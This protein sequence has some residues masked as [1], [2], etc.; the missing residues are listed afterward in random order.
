MTRRD[1]EQGNIL[2]TVLLIV[3]VLSVIAVAVMDDIR[4]AVRRA[5]N[6]QER[7]QADFYAI[8][9]E[10][11]AMQLIGQAVQRDPSRTLLE[12]WA[13]EPVIFPLDDGLIEAR[14]DDASNCFNLNALVTGGDGAEREADETHVALLRNL[15]VALDVGEGDAEGLANAAAD[16]IDSDSVP[17]PQGAEDYYYQGLAP[18]YRAA[19]TLMAEVS[20]VRAV[21]GFTQEIYARVAPFLCAHPTTEFSEI[22]VN[23]LNEDDAPLLMM[24][25]GP[26]N[27][28]AADA[29]SAIAA[30]GPNGYRSTDDFW[31]EPAFA[32][33]LPT[34]P[35]EL[36][37]TLKTRY[38]DL[39]VRVAY[40]QAFVQQQS[41]LEVRPAR[42]V[43][44]ISRRYGVAP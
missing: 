26:Q 2:I 31:A 4:F 42:D 9:A 29:R 30:R 21:R 27:L 10:Q 41:V 13:R 23:T 8:G 35:E 5:A 39:K 33:K 7:A 14:I 25:L 15:L 38:Y 18:P 3:A 28:S 40:M 1:G 17:E 11:F 36:P 19:N 16:W 6:V 37:V 22:N 43:A 44:V 24:L 12:G 32:G 20:E 34:Q